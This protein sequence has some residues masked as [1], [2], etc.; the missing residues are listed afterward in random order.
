M[1]LDQIMQR[2]QELQ[3]LASTPNGASPNTAPVSAVDSQSAAAFASMLQ[4]AQSQTM[5]DPNSDSGSGGS[6]AS[7]PGLGPYGGMLGVSDPLAAL[8]PL[9]LQSAGLTPFLNTAS[10]LTGIGAVN[11]PELSGDGS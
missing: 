4:Q 11:A 3:T 10:P 5:L 1:S 7:E 6:L 8:L 2:L 9:Q